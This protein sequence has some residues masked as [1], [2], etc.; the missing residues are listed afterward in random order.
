[1]NRLSLDDPRIE[2]LRRR[3]HDAKG[4]DWEPPCGQCFDAAYQYL[5]AADVLSTTTQT[6][7]EMR[8]KML[9]SGYVR[10][11]KTT[12][13]YVIDIDDVAV[14]LADRGTWTPGGKR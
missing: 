5:E 12:D 3:I 14:A 8:E 7:D 1:M 13:S 10:I 6:A 9:G 4:H 2:P 11:D